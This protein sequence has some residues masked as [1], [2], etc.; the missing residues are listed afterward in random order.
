MMTLLFRFTKSKTLP[1]VWLLMILVLLCIPGFALPKSEF[2]TGID[3]DKFVHIFLFGILVLLWN[4]HYAQK[5]TGLQFMVNTFFMVFLLVAAWG[6]FMEFIQFYFIPN[7][8]FDI[9]D[10][11]ADLIGSSLAYGFSNVYFLKK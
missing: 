10:I 6:I 8:D 3:I 7:R 5:N 1:I 4:T 9:A 11:T 2:L